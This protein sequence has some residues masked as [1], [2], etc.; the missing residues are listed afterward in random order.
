[1]RISNRYP[2]RGTVPA[3][4]FGLGIWETL[5]IVGLLIL[6]FG[7]RR[8]PSL[9]RGIGAGIRNFKGELTEG[10]SSPDAEDGDGRSD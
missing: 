7:A 6:L 10:D 9:A 3:L 8:I 2:A 5:L 4:V 1:M